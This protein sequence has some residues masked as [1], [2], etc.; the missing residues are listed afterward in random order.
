M[1]EL[2]SKVRQVR[3]VETL[4]KQGFHLDTKELSEPITKAVTATSQKLLE[5][6][7]S[8]TKAVEELD[9][10]NFHV[11]A[12]ELLNENGVIHSSLIRPIEKLLVPTNKS[13][14]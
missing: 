6:T 7:K 12:L 14:Y 3:L 11:K 13:Q 4:R 2:Q 8:T 9:E 1:A 10:R 5:E